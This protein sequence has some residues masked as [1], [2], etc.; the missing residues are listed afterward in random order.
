ME[1]RITGNGRI[2]REDETLILSEFI[3]KV[4]E[5]MSEICGPEFE[6]KKMS[7]TK[8]N[9]VELNG[10]SIREKDA[11]VAPTI[12]LDSMYEKYAEGMMSVAEVEN[13]ILRIYKTR[14]SL[15]VDVVGLFSDFS[16]VKERIRVRLINKEANEELLKD[17]PHEDFLDLA[18]IYIVDF[19]D[20]EGC[21]IIRNSHLQY[22]DVDF[23]D[24]KNIAE[25]NM[26]TYDDVVVKRFGDIVSE[27][28][29]GNDDGDIYDGLMYIMTN[30][31]YTF[32]AS[33]MLN[34]EK[35]S[36][37]AEDLGRGFYL[38]P[39]SVHEIIIVPDSDDID[40]EYMHDMVKSINRSEVSKEDFL[41]DSVY[42][43]GY[44]A[45]DVVIKVK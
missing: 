44:D 20:F 38:L 18:V 19:S 3:D 2:I 13:D 9:S 7:V 4:V 24:I 43:F 8:N 40:E 31:R 41:S 26:K 23:E 45:D 27:L 39:S 29:Q 30:S 21:I 36:E 1:N 32:G 42:Y 35:L 11:V 37:I 28:S 16:R 10:I 33:G 34:K 5:D 15:N 14:G 12:Y 6:V 25:S 22:W 17:V